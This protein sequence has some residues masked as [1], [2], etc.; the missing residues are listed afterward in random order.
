MAEQGRGF[1]AGDGLVGYD[2][3]ETI[4]NF[5]RMAKEGMKGT[6]VEILNI[7]IAQKAK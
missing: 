7:M 5:G 6:D 1:E 3:E 4:K 2:V